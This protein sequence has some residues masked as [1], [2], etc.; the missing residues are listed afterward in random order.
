MNTNKLSITEQTPATTNSI[1]E[2]KPKLA[3]TSN[4]LEGYIANSWNGGIIKPVS[5]KKI[6]AGEKITNYSI[7]GIIRMATPKV[8]VAQKL[9]AT[10]KI[11]F[12]PNSRVWDNHEKYLS[13][14]GGA[15]TT[16]IIT[17]P[18]FEASQ[19]LPKA[20]TTNTPITDTSLWRDTWISSYIP[21][22]W[23]NTPTA[24]A[25]TMPKLSILPIR[26]FKAIWNDMLRHKTYDTAIG[27]FKTD[28][29]TTAEFSQTIPAYPTTASAIGGLYSNYVKRG[30][31]KDSYYT[32]YRTQSEGV[33]NTIS[34][35]YTNLMEH[36]EWQKK[37]AESRS[38]AENEQKNDWDIVA[39][40][41]GSIPVSD[42][43]VQY[44]GM[45]EVGINYQQVSQTTYNTADINPDQQTL[46]ATGAFSYTEFN[47]SLINYHHFKEDGY[48]H[49]IQQTSSDT[50]FET[51]LDR[52]ELN[53][54][55]DSEYRPDLKELK[56]DVLYYQE[57]NGTSPTGV[58]TKGFKRKFSE[59]FKLP[60]IINGDMTS[61]PIYQIDG[62][63]TNIG[64]IPLKKEFQFFEI[65]DSYFINEDTKTYIAKSIWKDY[66]DIL[67]N[68]N[69]AIREKI[70][71]YGDSGQPT[72]GTVWID[73][74]NQL[75][76]I[77]NTSCITN[78]PI[79]E[80]I[81]QDFKQWG[82]Q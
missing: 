77:A 14:K 74:A 1:A 46:G 7:S 21:R 35:M 76:M 16:K 79:D 36:N 15:T 47:I 29:V 8:P 28:T 26:G 17:K 12:V 27:E 45:K 60:N 59:Y 55:Y 30:R 33:N 22:I 63:G 69:L 43:K 82:E 75:F 48:I 72:H 58:Y 4:L 5:W 2:T 24:A 71:S 49:I 18:A 41:R 81:K 10:F 38:Q 54:Q 31:R 65:S 34:P 80:K 11:F 56:E 44:L 23:T 3:N 19:I 37:I 67:I 40:L 64:E 66:T 70:N 57:S 6:M 13:Q 61:S 73:G 39:E 51:G 20:P 52:N 9:S 68:K 42:G 32:N 53:I 62:T 50:V 25:M 78:Q